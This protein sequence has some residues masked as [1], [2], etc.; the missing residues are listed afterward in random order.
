MAGEMNEYFEIE[1]D[2]EENSTFSLLRLV[3][4]LIENRLFR[5]T[6]ENSMETYNHELFRKRDDV[7]LSTEGSP[8]T[9]EEDAALS[10][11]E[12][13]KCYICLETIEVG[14]MVVRLECKH[15]F[16]QGCAEEA[17]AHQHFRCPL[18]RQA[19]PTHDVAP[20]E[21]NSSGHRVQFPE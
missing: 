21:T 2:E 18:C 9:A 14:N 12:E 4:T 20:A 10:S 17:V 5:Q 1:D 8:W 6:V 11:E 15:R 19:I 7:R 3:E 13:K 16:H